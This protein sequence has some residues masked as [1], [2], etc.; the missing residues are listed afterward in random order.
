MKPYSTEMKTVITQL[1]KKHKKL[2]DFQTKDNF[3]L[4]LE[5]DD[6]MPLV[7]E[8]HKSSVTITHYYQQN[9]DL[10]ADPDME[11]QIANDK[12]WHPVAL[13][14]WNGAYYRARWSENGKEYINPKQIKEQLSFARMW[15]KNIKA[16]GW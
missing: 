7:I 13:Q 10:I 8:R 14:L 2:E 11:F 1:L 15:A 6:Y 9:G 5:K 12:E 3:H 4:R 16:Q